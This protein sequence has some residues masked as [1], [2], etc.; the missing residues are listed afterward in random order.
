MLNYLY[1]QQY[2]LA[3]LTALADDEDWS[4]GDALSWLNEKTDFEVEI[5]EVEEALW[6]SVLSE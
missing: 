4:T 5:F 3:A 2:I 6:A 1:G